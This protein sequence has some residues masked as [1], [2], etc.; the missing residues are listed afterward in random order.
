MA[1]AGRPTRKALKQ[2]RSAEHLGARRKEAEAAG[3]V[4]TLA[5][6]IDQLR[7]SIAQLPESKR[8]AAAV[9]ATRMLDELR[10]GI[11]ES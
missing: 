8:S 9:Q 1:T 2:A 11:T 6:A 3:P 10:Q 7:S 5:V 4:A